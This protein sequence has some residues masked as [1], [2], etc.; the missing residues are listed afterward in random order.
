M[1]ISTYRKFYSSKL[2]KKYS[3]STIQGI[4]LVVYYREDTRIVHRE[5]TPVLH[6]KKSILFIRARIVHYMGKY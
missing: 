4:I 3:N 6:Y 1:Y 2:Y 5:S